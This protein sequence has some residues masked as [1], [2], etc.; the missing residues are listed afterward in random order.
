MSMR[1]ISDVRSGLNTLVDTQIGNAFPV[2][3]KVYE[4]IDEIEYVAAVYA[5]GRSRDISLRL[6]HT[7]E[8]VE[9]QY[10]GDPEWTVLFKF[11][12]LLGGDMVDVIEA[13]RLLGIQLAAL[14]DTLTA[15]AAIAVE[16][17]NSALSSKVA[18]KASED[19]AKVSEL[20]IG[21]AAISANASKVAA[22]ASATA[23]DI[24][25]NRADTRATAAAASAASA[26]LQSVNVG[27]L[28][29]TA[30]SKAGEATTSA[31]TATTKA[32]E[33]SASA[34]DAAVSAAASSDSAQI[35]INA[36]NSASAV[37]DLAIVAVN[38]SQEA[39]AA[40]D[41]AKDWATLMGSEVENGFG[42]SAKQYAA[43]ASASANTTAGIAEEIQGS[44]AN[45]SAFA[46]TARL[47]AVAA[48]ASATA[49][50]GNAVLTAA[51]V[52]SSA[53]N[54]LAAETSANTIG[55][56]AAE[57]A[58]SALLAEKWADS[59]IEV[60]G[61]KFSAKYWASQAQSSTTGAITYRGNHSALAGNFPP[62]AVLGD[63]YRIS[64]E[65]TIDG[66]LFR[67]NDAIVYN[68]TEWSI[69]GQSDVVYTV[70][71]RKGDVV[72]TAA[73]VGLAQ[74]DNTADADKPVSTAQQTALDLKSN[75]DGPA[76]TGV[77][78][79][80]TADVGTN[81]T[82][83]ATTAFVG[84]EIASKAAP[85]SH[86]TDD[87]TGHSVVSGTKAGFM[88]V[89]DKAKLDGLPSVIEGTGVESVAGRKGK[90]VLV[91]NDVGLGNVNNTSDSAKPISTA[92]QTALD[93]KANISNPTFSGVVS[94]ISK[95]M[96]GLGNV[97]NTSDVNKP[98]SAAMNTALGL[99][100]PTE[101]PV[102]TG[103]VSGLSKEMVG[104][105]SVDN[106]ADVDKPVSTAQLAALNQK[107]SLASPTFTGTV[108]G[109]TKEMVGLGSVENTADS[110]KSVASAASTPWLGITGKPSVIA[111][112]IDAAAA[113]TSIGAGTSN[114]VIGTTA[115]TAKAG[116]YAPAVADVTGL[117]AVLATKVD[118][119]TGKQLTTEDFSSAEKT[120]L[121][122][123]ATGAQVNVVP[124]VATVTG[125]TAELAAKAPLASPNFTGVPRAPTPAYGTNT[126]QLATMA[127]VQAAIAPKQDILTQAT[128]GEMAA[129]V[130]NTA[131]SMSP[132]NI[133]QAFDG[134]KPMR[135]VLLGDSLMS[136]E[137]A[138]PMSCGGLLE[139]WIKGSVPVEV[140]NL[141]FAGL[142]FY[143]TN[144]VAR[145]GAKTVQQKIIEL[146][147]DMVI[148]SLGLND[149]M[150]GAYTTE[151]QRSLTQVKTDAL[152]FFSALRTA[153]PYA[154]FIF[155]GQNVAHAPTAVSSLIND[156]I[157]PT[158][159][160]PHTSGH[161]E[162]AFSNDNLAKPLNTATKNL[163]TNMRNFV[164]Y[165]N[166]LSYVTSSFMM[167][168][169]SIH[170][171]GCGGVDRLHMRPIGQSLMVGYIVEHLI[172]TNAITG[173]RAL[174]WPGSTNADFF[175]A[176][177]TTHTNW[178]LHFLEA[179]NNNYLSLNNWFMGY[180]HNVQYTSQVRK[181]NTL[182][183]PATTFWY[184][185]TDFPPYTDIYAS[186]NN[187]S[188]VHFGRTDGTGKNAALFNG[189]DVGGLG[190]VVGNNTI[191]F[192]TIAPVGKMATIAFPVT[193]T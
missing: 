36:S 120:K 70:A 8:L 116:N 41:K 146:A 160:E 156:K 33:A 10:T 136:Q 90:V 167:D 176:L 182:A 178:S 190:F 55:N 73:D 5:T 172:A 25:A 109:I 24:S 30:I 192:V 77:P 88:S 138:M 67:V 140:L 187:G 181:T 115:S 112:G 69:V 35:S 125:L 26:S 154:K 111:S 143:Q 51:D 131:R 173:I 66:T 54:A 16:A 19:A 48:E 151:G 162:G 108:G 135:I 65:G 83:L 43:S 174:G 121:A 86:M 165:V 2:V 45:A 157:M 179:H 15:D 82:Q 44:I 39:I 62:T 21:T 144:T 170:R 79:A 117:S 124:T 97:D 18:A 92:Q 128:A 81:T 180:N 100:A 38:K 23:A 87:G 105:G 13:Q 12:D 169:F 119:V 118:V 193:V 57:A 29:N 22:A 96:V 28:V 148:V 127:A 102:F 133:K 139:A 158:Y 9:W 59:D 76:F 122:G 31:Q 7:R 75:L 14:Q 161:L 188:W 71:G 186:I 130:S 52:V 60:E 147:P 185:L 126:T 74:A 164:T 191:Q 80:P 103:V 99:K 11:S 132:L 163:V 142:T 20:S 175:Y 72:L 6:S 184:F 49:T 3:R 95:T 53:A 107:A 168:I 1:P 152:N 37:A 189:A 159:Q 104:L 166:G 113:R 129:G 141:S 42:Y 68:G 4:H 171:A 17:K 150:H 85:I 153:L 123:I 114:L 61:G 63:F 56:S 145:F 50:A 84:A 98:V 94:G 137:P 101:S 32:A 91:A 46:E 155:G 47:S 149:I 93:Q 110:T 34:Q 89:A 134:Q 183:S 58:A 106:T 177:N 78:V 64:A 40:A 27:T